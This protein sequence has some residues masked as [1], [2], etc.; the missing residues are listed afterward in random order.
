MRSIRIES[1]NPQ[2]VVMLWIAAAL[3]SVTLF[4]LLTG[5][6]YLKID[7]LGIWI[8]S[9]M[10]LFFQ[11]RRE[12]AYLSAHKRAGVVTFGIIMCVY[13]FANIPLGFG[14][15]P[16][17]IGDFSI[18]L[19]GLGL[20]LFGLLGYGSLLLQVSFPLIAV[21]GF[22][23][24]D[25][26]LRNEGWLGAPLIP[27]IVFFT[28]GLLSM[29]GIHVYSDG[30]LISFAS[31]TGDSINLAIVGDCTGIWSLGTFTVSAIIV[32]ASF[33]K[34]RTSFGIL[35]I[36]IGYLGTYTANI[37]R[38]FLIGMS[39]YFY[40]SAGVIETAHVHIGWIVFSIWMVVFWYYFFTRPLGLSLLPNRD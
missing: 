16:Y 6:S 17:S 21:L 7:A 36:A 38:I 28:V 33:P 18:L 14:N 32:L 34:G 12:I 1:V 22:Q 39:G 37:G 23:A 30:N 29:A 40:G 5:A 10:A 25:V 26:F 4:L 2:V 31:L 35:L 9:C 24:Y 27:S 11:S 3:S 8:L 15:P 20:V 13:S 19:A